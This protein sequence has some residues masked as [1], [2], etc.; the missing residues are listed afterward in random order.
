MQDLFGE[1][2]IL[3]GT[4]PYTVRYDT[5][6][7]LS[8]DTQPE[9]QLCWGCSVYCYVHVVEHQQPLLFI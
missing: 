2:S 8:T 1:V 9:C 4:I 5:L 6:M 3:L 7:V